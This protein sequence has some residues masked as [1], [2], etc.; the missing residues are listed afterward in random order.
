M[1][2]P[3]IHTLWRCYKVLTNTAQQACAS[4]TGEV[5]RCTSGDNFKGY[6]PRDTE[7]RAVITSFQN[8]FAEG[9][10]KHQVTSGNPLLFVQK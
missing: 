1:L 6:W 7:L 9:C 2:W 5:A 10:I 3:F 8:Q 4:D